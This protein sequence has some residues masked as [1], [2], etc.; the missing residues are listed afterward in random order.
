[1]FGNPAYVH[2]DR[3]TSFLSKDLKDWLHSKNIATSRTCPYNPRGNGQCERY[4]A[5]IWKAITLACKSRNIDVKFWETVLPDAPHS[6]R[7]L[8]CTATNCTPHEQ[9]FSFPHKSSY[10]ESIPSWLSNP[11]PV[12]RKHHVRPS[13]YDPMA[14]DLC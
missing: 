13:K 3:D 4:N 6:I 7:S 2:N 9:L 11:G 8:L 10:G 12:S 1:M 5:T 14:D